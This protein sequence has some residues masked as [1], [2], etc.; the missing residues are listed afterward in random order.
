MFVLLDNPRMSKKLLLKNS[1]MKYA[2]LSNMQTVIK[3]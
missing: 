3:L 2:V 1:N